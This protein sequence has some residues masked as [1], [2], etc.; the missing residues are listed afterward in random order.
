MP[1]KAEENATLLDRAT[2]PGSRAEAVIRVLEGN[3]TLGSRLFAPN[4]M[5]HKPWSGPR[6]KKGVRP[7][8]AI[9]NL[10]VTVEDAIESGDRV[11][12]RWRAQ[13]TH[14]GRLTGIKPTGNRIDVTGITIYRFA[15][16]RIVESWAQAD[17]AALAQQCPQIQP[18]IFE[19]VA[20]VRTTG[21]G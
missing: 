19:F 1:T 7:K 18:E 15:G 4:Y 2:V 11:V 6:L 21:V 12:V 20:K 5:E 8:T 16:G 9:P 14:S 3:R 13:G 17:M 10:K